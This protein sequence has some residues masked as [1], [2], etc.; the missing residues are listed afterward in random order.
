MH[1]LL[2]LLATV[3]SAAAPPPRWVASVREETARMVLADL[4]AVPRSFRFQCR[5]ATS[6]ARPARYQRPL[7]ISA[8]AS[9]ARDAEE[10]AVRA[11]TEALQPVVTAE[12]RLRQAAWLRV[13]A[14]HDTS[15]APADRPQL[16]TVVETISAA[17][18]P[19][20]PPPTATLE[21]KAVTL[22]ASMQ[23]AL[24]ERTLRHGTGG[25]FAMSCRVKEA[26]FDCR[27]INPLRP[28]WLRAPNGDLASPMRGWLF[29]L[30]DAHAGLVSIRMAPV[31]RD[32]EP[33]EGTDV[34]FALNL[35][36]E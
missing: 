34:Q 3:E 12:D 8:D 6:I 14:V 21:L 32:G 11:E 17:D 16:F 4:P 28:T 23:I 1:S 9:E 15:D 2:L 27:L 30:R 20:R 5:V 18:I 35:R 36:V 25:S 10:L 24:S 33:S 7:C 31:T 29:A 19:Q 22:A 26:A 13:A